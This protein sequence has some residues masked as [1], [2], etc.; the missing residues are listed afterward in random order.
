MNSLQ[1]VHLNVKDVRYP[2]IIAWNAQLEESMFLSVNATLNISVQNFHLQWNVSSL[3]AR[4]SAIL[5]SFKRVTVLNVDQT[6]LPLLRANVIRITLRLIKCVLVAHRIN[7]TIRVK[8]NAFH[9]VTGASN[10]LI[11]PTNAPS[12]MV[13]CT[14]TNRI[15]CAPIYLNL[16]LLIQDKS[17]ARIEWMLL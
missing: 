2:P 15:A 9:A 7:T 12:V 10:V 6:D 14:C 1:I 11:Q 13:P 8:A 4:L 16:S 5:V 17:I 3:S